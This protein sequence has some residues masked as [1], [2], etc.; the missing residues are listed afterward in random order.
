M[1]CW[2]LIAISYFHRLGNRLPPV[3]YDVAATTASKLTSG[4]AMSV[5]PLT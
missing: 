3:T 5:Q 2:H 1:F 4:P